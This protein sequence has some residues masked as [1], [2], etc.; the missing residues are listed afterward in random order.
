MIRNANENDARAI[1]QIRIDG[2]KSAYRGII[3]DE[4]LDSI[5]YEKDYQ[6]VYDRILGKDKD[7][8]PNTIV[9][10]DDI[11]NEVLGFSSFGEINTLSDN[12][13][14]CEL[15]AIYVKPENKG[16]GIGKQMLEYINDY[17]K[18]IGKK[19]MILFCLKDNLLSRKFYLKNNGIEVE[20]IEK[21]IGN[22]KLKQIGYKFKL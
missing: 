17:F 19:N 3:S 22:Q 4:Y 20:E 6:R 18:S 2:W 21:E 13:Y 12:M 9:F 16:Q 10:V 15:Y 5:D 11:T 7:Y 8:N 14:D 1:S